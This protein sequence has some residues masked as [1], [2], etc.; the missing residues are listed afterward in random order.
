M[1]ITPTFKAEYTQ[2]IQYFS[3]GSDGNPLI[4]ALSQLANNSIPLIDHKPTLVRVYLNIE[5]NEIWNNGIGL[6][7]FSGS[8]G[9]SSASTGFVRTNAFNAPVLGLPAF[10]IDR[11]R[12][13]NTL[14]FLIPAEHC[15]GT[16]SGV[17]TIEDNFIPDVP[18][19]YFFKLV[20][21]EVP[22]LKIHCLFIHYKGIDDFGN[23]VDKQSNGL[24]MS[25]SLS[26]IL[27]A[28]PINGFD[29][30]GCEVFEWSMKKEDDQTV[31]EAVEQSWWDLFG[32]I[33][34]A[35]ANAD[36]DAIYMS[37]LPIEATCAGTCGLG[38]EGVAA[39]FSAG[40]TE[41]AA[42]ELGHAM[43]R[44]HTPCKNVSGGQDES[45]PQYG[46]FQRGSIGQYGVDIMSLNGGLVNPGTA[47][48]DPATVC[49]FLSYCPPRWMSP[50]TYQEIYSWNLNRGN[51]FY[52][53]KIDLGD[54]ARKRPMQYISF[55][56]HHG[57]RQSVEIRNE[58]MITR[59]ESA[60][61]TGD[62]GMVVDIL[63]TKDRIMETIPC[64]PGSSCGNNHLPFTDYTAW[65]PELHHKVCFII[66]NKKDIIHVQKVA[67]KKPAINSFNSH[68]IK[69]ESIIFLN[70]NWKVK[71][72]K[73]DMR[74]SI[75]F[76]HD[77][78]KWKSLGTNIKKTNLTIS[79]ENLPGGENCMVEL[80]ASSGFRSSIK[81]IEGINIP[82]KARKIFL[83][84]PKNNEQFEFGAPVYFSGSG[85]S[86][87][88]GLSR[89]EEILWFVDKEQ[90]LGKGFQVIYHELPE[91]THEI[92]L[93]V[94]DGHGKKLTEKIN[95]SIVKSF[96]KE[97]EG[98]QLLKVLEG[99]KDNDKMQIQRGSSTNLPNHFILQELFS[100]P[101]SKHEGNCD[102]KCHNS[103]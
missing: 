63:G 35:H 38:R 68:I 76:S 96:R 92:T 56:V 87:D 48:M 103:R 88:H 26:Y 74:F 83:H 13:N 24:D 42:H 72:I 33:K 77:G 30:D 29:F 21:K 5:D 95:I 69:K 85:Y 93:Q 19:A 101:L 80:T 94:D 7:F 27:R 17:I 18:V 71:K 28:Y 81:R 11:G 10:T 61:P 78:K 55:R 12:I 70:L 75:R 89:P 98:E 99:M 34:D 8:I 66:R 46:S 90:L 41:N 58:F 37:L 44:P 57:S 54:D 65:L 53:A 9:Y 40:D 52:S 73:D 6:R 3:Y 47:L 36:T 79:T 100:I 45:Y 64:S 86:P 31:G 23:A 91:G 2:S 59:S 82:R 102:C 32:A 97:N 14:N 60:Q 16:L 15:V 67:Q 50:H 25:V 1:V 4:S 51:T 20:F 43:G 84:I 39:L 22:L 62:S 49:D